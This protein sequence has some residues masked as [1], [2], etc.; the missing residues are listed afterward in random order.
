MDFTYSEEQG[1]VRDLVSQIIADKVSNETLKALELR[2]QQAG[3]AP[4][5]SDLW[6]E[7]ANAGLLG[8][9][10]DTECGGAGLDFVALCLVIEAL[11][12]SA[13]YI[14]FLE[15]AVYG[16]M[17]I[18]KFGTPE[19][20]SNW[21]PQ[22]ASGDLI[23]TAGLAESFGD[24]VISVGI[25]PTTT[26]TALKDGGWSVN[27]S[28]VCVSAGLVADMVLVPVTIVDESGN[29]GRTGVFVIDTSAAGVNLIPQETTTGRLEAIMEFSNVF[30][31][32]LQ[33]LNGA[34]GPNGAGVTNGAGTPGT[35]GDEIVRFMVDHARAALCVEQAGICEAAL[36]LIEEY[37]KS[38]HQFEKPIATF[39]AVGQ[40]AADAY[41]DTQAINLTAWQAAW[42]LSTGLPAA[43]EIAVAKY[44]AAEAGQ[45][46]LLAAMH[47]HGGVGMDRD[48]PLHRYFLLTSQIAFTLGGATE[49]LRRLGR[50][51]VCESR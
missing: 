42:R 26:A 39:Q 35:L 49:S 17:T 16:A 31:D 8:I 32:E 4:F 45:R 40:R 46:V 43:D 3:L 10:I 13:A 36:G 41:I 47:L 6:H 33:H 38:R 44:W 7:L 14:P 20:V 9:A 11:G 22:I 30:V 34:G 29:S 21:L 23:L 24:V 5:D 28:K 19:Q 1:A 27:G 48:Y 15:T 37:T 2:S 51:L 25:P 12:K 18:S 50:Q